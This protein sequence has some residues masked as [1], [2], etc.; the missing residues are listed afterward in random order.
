MANLKTAMTIE[1]ILISPV[2]FL[3]FFH[4]CFFFTS[5]IYNATNFLDQ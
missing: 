3:Q 4:T 2:S 5:F 1:Q